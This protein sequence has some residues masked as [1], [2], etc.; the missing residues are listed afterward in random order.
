MFSVKRRVLGG[1]GLGVV[2]TYS[3]LVACACLRLRRIAAPTFR[4]VAYSVPSYSVFKERWRWLLGYVSVAYVLVIRDAK[5]VVNSPNAFF[6]I[7]LCIFLINGG[8][9][10]LVVY[11]NY[12]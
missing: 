2:F 9:L 8:F 4:L 11:K 6:F 1:S 7:I 12:L 5:T 10:R 3:H